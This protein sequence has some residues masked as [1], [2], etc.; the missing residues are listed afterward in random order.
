MLSVSQIQRN[1]HQLDSFDIIEVVDKKRNQTKGYFLDST[2]KPLIEKI[3][4]QKEQTDSDLMK[5]VG[6]VNGTQ[7][8]TRDSLRDER[9]GKYV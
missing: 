6:I 4:H 5:I 1:L 7:E 3:I 2:Y 9:L 8:V